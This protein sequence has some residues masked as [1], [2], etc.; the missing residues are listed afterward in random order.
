MKLNI[1]LLG[2]IAAM[3]ISILKIW[4]GF[5]NESSAMILDGAQWFFISS[6]G[7]TI[8]AFVKRFM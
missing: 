2:L 4:I 3:A 6:I 8:S 1:I 7:L 5:D